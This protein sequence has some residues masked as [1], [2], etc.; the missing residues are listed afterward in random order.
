[1]TEPADQSQRSAALDVERSF[2]VQAPAGSGKTELLSLRFLNLLATCEQPEEILAITFTRKAAS[3]MR[4]RIVASLVAARQRLAC[5]ELA[6]RDELEE[7][8]FRLAHTALRRSE[9]MS[10]HLI[11][12]PT[13]LR[14]QTI[15]SFCLYLANRAP[16][17]SRLGGSGNVSDD[18]ERCFN[19]AI[20]ALFANLDSDQS[21]AGD[22]ARM[23]AH[24]DNDLDAVSRLLT[25]LLRNR[26]QW[27]THVLAIR[28]G[29]A[30]HHRMLLQSV[31]ELLVESMDDA[32]RLLAGHR[33]KIVE[34]LNFVASYNPQSVAG[35]SGM[36]FPLQG[37]PPAQV[38][39]LPLWNL[40]AGLLLTDKHQGRKRLDARAGFPAP[41]K[42]DKHFTDL[43]KRM[44]ASALQLIGELVAD[45]DK[46]EA[47]AYLQRLPDPATEREQWDFL[48]ALARVLHHLSSELL[49]V[50]G[51]MGVVDHTQVGAAA[52]QALGDEDYPTDLALLL[53]HQ[54]RHIL[55]D[56]F[57]DTSE[58][59]RKLLAG[60][61]REWYPDD[62]RTLF[63][64]GDAMQS[65]YGF[66]NANVGIY[67]SVQE[68]GLGN[69]RPEKLTL[70]CNFRSQANVVGW[71][72]RVFADA[73]PN[74]PLPSRGAVPYAPST[75]TR[76][77]LEGT[78]VRVEIHTCEAHQKATARQQEAESIAAYIARLRKTRPAE[79]IAILVRNRSH[80]NA[81][82]PVLREHNIGWHAT[83]ID[84]LESLPVIT[85]LVSL[86]RALLNL[87]DRAAWYSILRAPWCGLG[88]EDMLSLQRFA[89]TNSVWYALE[90]L[91]EVTALGAD[92]RAR[93]EPVSDVLRVALAQRSR[94]TLRRLVEMTWNL[95][96]GRDLVEDEIERSSV[97]RFFDL[98]EEQEHA[99]GLRDLKE[100]RLKLA[101]AFVPSL[102]A[103]DADP[104]IHILT[105]HKAKGLEFD[106]VIL[107]ALGDEPLSD[108]RQ[109][110][111]WHERVNRHGDSSL[112]L[113]TLSARGSEDQALYKLL[114]FEKA[115]KAEL[116]DT[117]L[118]YIA[119]TRARISA[120][121][122]ATAS[123]AKDGE[124][125]PGKRSLLARIWPQLH[126]LES[127]AL[128]TLAVPEP[129]QAG[130]LSTARAGSYPQRTPLRRFVQPLQLDGARLTM[131]RPAAEDP[132]PPEQA[133]QPQDE[134]AQLK[135]T[136]MHATLEVLASEGPTYL[137]GAGWSRLRQYWRL[138]LRGLLEDETVLNASID[139]MESMLRQILKDP[140]CGWV[141]DT[142][143][144]DSQAELVI[145]SCTADT[146]GFH[147]VDRTFI[148]HEGCRWVIDYKT[149]LPAG[150]ESLADF[151]ARMKTLHAAQ[152]RRYRRLFA[153]MEN[154]RVRTAL[155]LCA[156][157][158]LVEID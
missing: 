119:C 86:T 48:S 60:L 31:E 96:G 70:T 71:V 132:N 39:S 113:A 92:G 130:E 59:Q 14:I 139:S 98:L 142:A 30:A 134:I 54:L 156:V 138:N 19:E 121:L 111:L 99:G 122:S 155:L 12:N 143:L 144:K 58:M 53:D 67:L 106:H 126:S 34:L 107:P 115:R 94:I 114:Q 118:M 65:C 116:E 103:G 28:D 133:R 69:I 112:L 75:A 141:F 43:R 21:A 105:M 46:L 84:R 151:I 56:E 9:S 79:S 8:R 15:D 101:K 52:L 77:P 108:N 37:L 129:G 152:L 93:L 40:L 18:V 42:Q 97:A 89:D 26:D 61:T 76:P 72:N 123:R 20:L 24:M 10:W 154:R 35:V 16:V 87:A 124:Y 117:R 91:Q 41:D 88:I 51:R 148:D 13:R 153:L 109:L 149:S 131:P 29:S 147:V 32:H 25:Q 83:D 82:L 11:E 136:L 78:G 38:E 3:E 85:D 64:V 55:V 150:G 1:M 45:P 80:L 157:P 95:L 74:R 110:L 6:F 17:L 36:T 7:L 22:I 62:G 73:F 158:S 57:Q 120:L 47:L 127:A 137:A 146:L 49:L 104:S 44:H 128:T 63:L 50:F 68:S 81:I 66:R 33:P 100:F 125:A 27:L 90:R 135:G 2:I 5:G 102:D 4:E 140:G 23:L 145:S